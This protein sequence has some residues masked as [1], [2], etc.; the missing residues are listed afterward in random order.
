MNPILDGDVLNRLKALTV[1][2]LKLD[3]LYQS[4]YPYEQGMIRIV[5]PDPM[6]HTASSIMDVIA[7]E[8]RVIKIEQYDKFNAVLFAVCRDLGIDFSHQGPVTCHVFVS[9]AGAE[10]FPEHT[11][12]D[13][14]YLFMLRGEKRIRVEDHEHR[15]RAGN[16]LFIPHGTPH[17]A[18]TDQDSVMLSFGLEHFIEEKL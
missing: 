9:P 4:V 14:V 2:C 1:D 5:H 8:D 11:D 3:D 12:P 18:F 15:L 7:F 10:S 6:K 17:E 16:G 13:D